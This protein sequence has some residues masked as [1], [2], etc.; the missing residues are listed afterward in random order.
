MKAENCAVCLAI[1]GVLITTAGLS[2][3]TPNRPAAQTPGAVEYSIEKSGDFGYTTLRAKANGRSY[4]LID[5]AKEQCLE[6]VDQRDFDG[7]G[8]KDALVERI[9][10]C[11]GNCCPNGFFFVSAFPN[12]RFEISGDLSDSW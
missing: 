6:I 10:A 9:T 8:L 3:Q 7:N 12:G 1:A 2:A 5:K 11:G 4:T